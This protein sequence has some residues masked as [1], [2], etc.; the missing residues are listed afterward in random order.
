MATTVTKPTLT[1]FNVA[2]K[3]EIARLILEEAAVDYDFVAINNW[4]EQKKE[5]T[6]AGK[7]HSVFIIF[8]FFSF[9][10]CSF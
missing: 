3:A 10:A 7:L 4:A 9:P 1:Y 8:L 5:L 6:D 2:A